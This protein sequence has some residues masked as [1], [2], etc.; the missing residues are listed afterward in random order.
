MQWFVVREF[1]PRFIRW[2]AE[3]TFALRWPDFQSAD[4]ITAHTCDLWWGPISVI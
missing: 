3:S 1:L 2:L 4:E